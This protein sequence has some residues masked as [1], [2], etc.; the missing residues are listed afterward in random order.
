MNAQ[1]HT[2]YTR[3]IILL[4]AIAC[5]ALLPASSSYAIADAC[6][7]SSDVAS[8]ITS[9]PS[10]TY[11]I[12]VKLSG[13]GQLAD[14]QLAVDNSVSC[15]VLTTMTAS[16]N[17]W[18]KAGAVSVD[19]HV[20]TNLT[21]NQLGDSFDYARP[22]VMFISRTRPACTPTDECYVT[23]Q[24]EKAVL[25]PE[26]PSSDGGTLHA[27]FMPALTDKTIETVRYYLDGEY[28]YQTPAIE[29]FNQDLVSHYG[30]TI[31]RVVTFS[32]GR[33]AILEPEKTSGGSDTIWTPL[34]SGVTKYQSLLLWLAALLLTVGIL[35]GIRHIVV[36]SSN[37]HYWLHAHGFI[38]D[39]PAK[40]LTNRQRIHIARMERVKR[41]AS[42]LGVVALIIGIGAILVVILDSYIVRIANVDGV[43]MERTLHSGER[44]LINRTG[45]TVASISQ[46]DF[47]PDRGDV[48]AGN[49]VSRYSAGGDISGGSLVIKR[50]IGLPGERI[51]IK[52]NRITIYNSQQPDGFNP[53]EGSSWSTS[54]V[55]ETSDRRLD[56]TLAND[57][58]FIIGDN[59]PASIDSRANGPLPLRNI[60]GIVW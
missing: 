41:V 25:Q 43:S 32:D 33:T 57:E 11:D 36:V 34:L 40:P 10:D 8:A 15:R 53:D 9:L 37:R 29:P 24:G 54:V 49:Q 22:N 6:T 5:S 55:P 60:V 46:R 21:S 3:R 52:G 30:Q 16:G 38:K 31:S 45:V 14:I 17:T 56:I 12:Y 13:P 23:I 18:K 58:V 48:I 59:R 26:H 47:I 20:R 51:V 7:P 19:D 28:M 4:I 27:Y 42:G 39:P 2:A 50:V 1:T 35:H 44:I